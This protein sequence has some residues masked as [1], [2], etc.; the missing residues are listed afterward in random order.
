M[1]IRIW[2]VFYSAFYSY[3]LTTFMATR[4]D[5]ET[6]IVVMTTVVGRSLQM[7]KWSYN[8]RNCRRLGL[9]IYI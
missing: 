3:S 4:L 5:I 6:S 2:V 8:G 7:T 1:C 9:R